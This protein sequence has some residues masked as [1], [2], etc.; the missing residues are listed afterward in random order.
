MR[1]PAGAARAALISLSL[2]GFLLLVPPAAPKTSVV[3]AAGPSVS[4]AAARPMLLGGLAAA[5]S[6]GRTLSVEDVDPANLVRGYATVTFAANVPAD[7]AVASI[8]AGG[9]EVVS[10][11]PALNVYEVRLPAGTPVDAGIAMLAALPGAGRAEPE[12]RSRF[13]FHPNDPL[14][15]SNQDY[16]T[17]LLHAEQAWDIQ[18]GDPRVVVAIVDSGVDINHPDLAGQIWTNPNPGHGGCGQD[19]HGCNFADPTR[20]DPSCPGQNGGAVPNPDV[21]P[22]FFHGTFVAGV[23]GA[24]TNNGVGIAGVVPHASLMPVKIGDCK[25]AFDMAVAQGILYAVQNG[26]AIVQLSVAGSCGPAP[27]YLSDA[28]AT[29]EQAGVILVAAAGNESRNCV[30]SPAN[31]GGVI[32]VGSTGRTGLRRAATSNWGPQ[33]AVVAPGETIVSTVP[34]GSAGGDYATDSGTSY[35]APL[36]AGLADLLLSQNPLLPPDRV[37]ALIQKGAAPLADGSEPGWAGAGRIDLA[38][39]LR[40]VPAGFFG[41]VRLNGADVPDGTP[42]EARVGGQLC[43]RARSQTVRGQSTYALLVDAGLETPGCGAPG[44]TVSFT[45][46]GS[47]AGDAPWK[48]SATAL[49]LTAPASAANATP[50]ATTASPTGAAGTPTQG[51]PA[52]FSYSAGWNLVAGP[53]GTTFTG[54]QPPL[55]TLQA[56]DASYETV[57]G[58]G[59]AQAGVGYWAFFGGDSLVTPPADG[60]PVVTITAPADRFVL[61]GNPSGSRTVTVSGAD[62]IYVYDPLTGQYRSTTTLAPGQG[63][64]ALSTAGGQISFQ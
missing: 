16:L 59:P 44:A 36:V 41:R 14:Y 17:T 42:V 46:N 60:P 34:T 6:S 25:G 37:L 43:G 23:V 7:R 12:V 27:S 2:F 32:A 38:A 49:D 13:A 55:F 30:D 64:W 54:A 28:I 51:A 21:S 53:A 52:A 57:Q 24:A 10:T 35:S 63:A 3:A 9:G 8:E 33:I 39:S 56:G 62:L 50:S 18:Q 40:L 26:A 45:V 1:L 5:P 47:P 19:V 58:L 20:F 31:V 11:I 22:T 4:L 61:V 48:A 15:Q 29:A